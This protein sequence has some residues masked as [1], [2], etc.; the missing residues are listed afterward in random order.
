[1]SKVVIKA[2]IKL[3]FAGA[4]VVPVMRFLGKLASLIGTFSV[5]CSFCPSSVSSPQPPFQS[6]SSPDMGPGDGHPTTPDVTSSVSRR[7]R[8]RAAVCVRA[9]AGDA[10]TAATWRRSSAR[11][12]AA[13]RTWPV[14]RTE[15]RTAAPAWGASTW[16]GGRGSMCL[17][18]LNISYF[19][20]KNAVA[21][22][23]HSLLQL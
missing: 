8:G 19:E 15:S 7:Y 13:R 21:S 6:P 17:V 18:V 22:A 10:A 4:S 5:W 23:R 3:Y 14:A 20:T 1:M 2:C 16:G 11:Q 9:G 12:N